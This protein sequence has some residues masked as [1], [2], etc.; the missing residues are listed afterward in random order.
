[1]RKLLIIA[2]LLMFALTVNA[3]VYTEP[4]EVIPVGPPVEEVIPVPEAPGIV[5]Q[6]RIPR[7]ELNIFEFLSEHTQYTTYISWLEDTGLAE[8][9]QQPGPYTVFALSNDA[10]TNSPQAIV[11]RINSDPNFK[12]QIME[13]S[14]ALGEYDLNDL[15]NADEGA[16]MSLQGEP[17]SIHITA[18]GLRINGERFVS[19]R[20]DDLFTNGIVNAVEHILLPVSLQSEF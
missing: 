17:Y 20:L 11:D 14:I 9:L 1:M 7:G 13:T 2:A 12:L 8:R 4:V 16:I 19:T 3:Q 10:I 5:T 15:Q 18:T 6:L